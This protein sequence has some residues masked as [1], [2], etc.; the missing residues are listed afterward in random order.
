MELNLHVLKG[1]GEFSAP[2][3]TPPFSG[4]NLQQ[5]MLFFFLPLDHRA[6]QIKYN[7]IKVC[8]C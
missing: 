8:H 7:E 2:L 6:D 4:T 3:I 5:N 1:V